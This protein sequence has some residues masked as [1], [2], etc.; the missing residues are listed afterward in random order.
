VLKENDSKW[1]D[2]FKK[3]SNLDAKIKAKEGDF[4]CERPP[5]KSKKLLQMIQ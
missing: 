1:V 2:C 4:K 3:A 5:F